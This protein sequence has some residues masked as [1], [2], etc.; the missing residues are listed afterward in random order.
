MEESL[1]LEL[2]LRGRFARQ[3]LTGF[4]ILAQKHV[5]IIVLSKEKNSFK[6]KNQTYFE[7]TGNPTLDILNLQIYT[8]DYRSKIVD[9]CCKKGIKFPSPF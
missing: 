7:I 9:S 6:K 4:K 1:D 5:K 2:E 3:V 8:K